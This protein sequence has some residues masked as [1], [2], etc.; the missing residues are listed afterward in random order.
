M[1]H[2]LKSKGK[3]LKYNKSKSRYLELIFINGGPT[4]FNSTQ[5]RY[6]FLFPRKRI[7]ESLVESRLLHGLFIEHWLPNKNPLYLQARE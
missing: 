7:L 2:L 4:I 5:N 6:D 1:K 3:F